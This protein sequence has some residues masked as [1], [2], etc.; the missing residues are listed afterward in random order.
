M[1]SIKRI[2]DGIDSEFEISS[3]WFARTWRLPT[4]Y[5][6]GFLEEDCPS[7]DEVV[8]VLFELL[9]NRDQKILDLKHALETAENHH[10]KRAFYISN[11]HDKM[12]KAG[13][14]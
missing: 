5:F 9:E 7:R 12:K 13:M 14:E 8:G 2:E 11:L 10:I 6:P 4:S 3:P 1:I